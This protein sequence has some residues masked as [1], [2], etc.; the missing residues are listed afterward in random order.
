MLRIGPDHAGHK[1]LVK[2]SDLDPE[3][4]EKPLAAE[5]D[6]IRCVFQESDRSE[7]GLDRLR[8]LHKEIS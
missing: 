1:W 6:M 3:S 5:N 2:D 4:E 8:I 7:D